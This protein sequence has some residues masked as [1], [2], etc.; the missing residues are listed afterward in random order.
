MTEDGFQKKN[1]HRLGAAPMKTLSVPLS[2]CIIH[3]GSTHLA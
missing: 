3:E 1:M 2:L